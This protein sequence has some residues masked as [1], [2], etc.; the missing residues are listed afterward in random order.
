MPDG[1]AAP[2]PP[3]P[4]T[5]PAAPRAVVLLSGGLDSATCLAIARRDGRECH[6]LTIAYGQRHRI[7]IEAARRTAALLGAAAHRVVT[8][9]LRAFGGSALTSDI[10]VPKSDE[11]FGARTR[12][13]A[14]AIPITYVPARNTIFLSYALAFAEV[15]DAAEIYIGV[16]EVDYSGYPDC[17]PAFIEAFQ[18]MADLAT[19]Q[20]VEEHGARVIAPLMHQSKAEIIQR[21][22]E[23]GVDYAQTLSCY[24]PG[25][26]AD[27]GWRACGRCDACRIRSAAFEQL[28]AID[29]AHMESR[30]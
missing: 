16:N 7:E 8:I 3:T 27:G 30:G 13:D 9:D 10:P 29:P 12:G 4:P 21:G 24:D 5:P 11:P 17:R 25:E 14:G 26:R 6:C 2:T 20:G 1:S 28:G 23:L 19:R 18:R 22:L 15:I